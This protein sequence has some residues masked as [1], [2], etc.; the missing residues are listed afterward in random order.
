MTDLLVCGSVSAYLPPIH[1]D[2]SEQRNVCSTEAG[3]EGASLVAAMRYEILDALPQHVD[4][5]VKYPG[6]PI[7]GIGLDRGSDEALRIKLC[8]RL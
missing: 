4:Q 3:N 7:L 1:R 2:P 6:E 5:A 8:A